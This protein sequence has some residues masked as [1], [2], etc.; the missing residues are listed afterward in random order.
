MIR[1]TRDALVLMA[2]LWLGACAEGLQLPGGLGGGPTKPA[3]SSAAKPA[4][5]VA[6]A[7]DRLDADWTLVRDANLRAGPGTDYA[8]L[9]ALEQGTTVRVEGRVQK[10]RWLRVTSGGRTGYLHESLARPVGG[11]AAAAVATPVGGEDE[12]PELAPVTPAPAPVGGEDEIEI[13]RGGGPAG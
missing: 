13:P 9:G 4:P 11:P 12:L 1:P 8:I 3:A 10:R 2:V 6:P 7:I 5:A